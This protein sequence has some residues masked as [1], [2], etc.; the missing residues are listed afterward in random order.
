[1][2]ATLANAGP[3]ALKKERLAIPLALS[4]SF[5]IL[6]DPFRLLCKCDQTGSHFETETPFGICHWGDDKVGF[7][8]RV[9]LAYQAPNLGVS[10]CKAPEAFWGCSVVESTS[11]PHFRDRPPF[12]DKPICACQGSYP[13]KL[14]QNGPIKSVHKHMSFIIPYQSFR[15]GSYI[16]QFSLV[17]HGCISKWQGSHCWVPRHTL[18]RSDIRD[19][20]CQTCDRWI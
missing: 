12:G 6:Q 17:K 11:K 13:G 20:P 4:V 18:R 1:M 8:G 19:H 10:C 14:I 16:C 3:Q 2:A 7:S 15:L 9:I 5:G